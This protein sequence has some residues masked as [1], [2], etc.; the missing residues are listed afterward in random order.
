MTVPQIPRIVPKEHKANDN[1]VF[2]FA[3]LCITKAAFR[4]LANLLLRA[5]LLL[6]LFLPKVNDCFEH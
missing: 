6:L 1:I 5:L 2:L 3:L 4:A